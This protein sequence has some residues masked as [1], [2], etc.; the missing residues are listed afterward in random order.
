MKTMDKPNGPAL[1]AILAGAIGVFV[2]G[3]MTTLAEASESVGNML[4]WVGPVGPLSGKT[5]M[6]VTV[7]LVAWII[8]GSMYKGKNVEPG[9]ITLWSWI[10]IVLGLL[11]TFP[12]FFDLFAK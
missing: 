6:G 5:G 3:L 8:L 7:W 11:G 10:L 4:R 1:A 9:R 2:I 12:K